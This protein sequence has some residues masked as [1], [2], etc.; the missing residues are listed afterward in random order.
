MLKVDSLFFDVDGTLVDSTKDI[1]NAMNYI[2]RTVGLPEKPPGK[3]VSYIGTGVKDLVRKS[4]GSGHA[5]LLDKCVELFSEYYSRH[6]HDEA[7]LYPHVKEVLEYFKNKRKFIL[8][9]RYSRFAAATLKGLGVKHYFED[10]FGGDD[11]ACLKPSPCIIDRIFSKVDIRKDTTLLV[12]DM[13]IDIQTGKNSGIKTC[14]VTYGLG[15]KEDFKDLR[16]D[17]TIGDMIELK[18]I[19]Q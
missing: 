5:D 3:I 16:P 11:E 12:G 10:I 8:T 1:V 9:N 15:K 19:I 7:V 18:K 6:S 17:Y 4:V 2:L 13:A 14:W